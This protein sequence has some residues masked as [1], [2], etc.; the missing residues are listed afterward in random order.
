MHAVGYTAILKNEIGI[1]GQKDA[2][3]LE[4]KE[5]HAVRIGKAN[6]LEFIFIF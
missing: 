2:N 3:K 6:G 4:I 1:K 5:I